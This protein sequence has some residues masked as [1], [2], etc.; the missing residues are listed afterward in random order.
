MAKPKKIKRESDG[1]VYSTEPNYVFADLFAGL[2]ENQNTQNGK[3]TLYIS[4]DKKQRAGK[5]VTL[6]EGFSGSEDE[7]I[8]LGKTLK[9]LCGAG[10][11]VKD[12]EILI[13][14]DHRDKVFKLLLNKG[15]NV[16]KKGG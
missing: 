11:A 3:T 5:Q 12:G 14:G 9:N 7:L 8:E 4:L 13:Q 6:I 15:H 1:I 16:K 2:S 10:G